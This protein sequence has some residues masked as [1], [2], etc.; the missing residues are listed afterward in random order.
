MGLYVRGADVPEGHVAMRVTGDGSLS[1]K[2]IVGKHSSLMVARRSPGYHS[3]PHC[4]DSEQLNYVLKGEIYIFTEHKA[5]HLQQGDFLRI[6]PNVIHWAW[7]RSNKDCE[8]LESH[9]PPL[10]ILPRDQATLLLDEGECA[11][12][13]KWAPNVFVSDEYMQRE[14]RLLDELAGRGTR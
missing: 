3:K 14:Q 12:D 8:L 4:H 2:Q 6:P 1:T 5:Y 9:A 7:N 13:I 11:G 10:D